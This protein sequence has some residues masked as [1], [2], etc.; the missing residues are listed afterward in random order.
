MKPNTFDVCA[1]FFAVGSRIFLRENKMKTNT[2]SWSSKILG[3]AKNFFE[4]TKDENSYKITIFGSELTELKK[5][6]H[7][8]IDE[9]IIFFR[10]G[11]R[12]RT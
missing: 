4:C 1:N 3:A 8:K 11:N 7:K 12:R 5:I 6:V 9:K 2:N 10:I